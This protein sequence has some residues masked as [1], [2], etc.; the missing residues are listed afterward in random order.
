[1]FLLFFL[2]FK[3]FCITP[4]AIEYTKLKLDLTI[5]TGASITVANEEIEISSL[6]AYKAIKDLIVKKKKHFYQAFYSFILC[7]KF[8]L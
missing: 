1:M 2:F 5:P 8:Q 4:V 7:H 3:N 6:V